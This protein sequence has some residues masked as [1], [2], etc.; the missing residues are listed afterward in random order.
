MLK[1]GAVAQKM[2][3]NSSRAGKGNWF[4]II[5]SISPKKPPSIV[6]LTAMVGNGRGQTLLSYSMTESKSAVSVSNENTFLSS[7]QLK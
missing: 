3:V 4:P 6:N 2:R 5:Q 1:N 7:G